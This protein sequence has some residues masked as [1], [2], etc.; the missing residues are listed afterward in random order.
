MR[1]ATALLASAAASDGAALFASEPKAALRLDASVVMTLML[2]IRAMKAWSARAL[3][4]LNGDLEVPAFV[5]VEALP[6]LGVADA[7]DLIN[8]LDYAGAL[9]LGVLDCIDT[10]VG[11]VDPARSWRDGSSLEHE[12]L[13]M[14][15]RVFT[16]DVLCAIAA[17]FTAREADSIIL[18]GDELSG[19]ESRFHAWEP[20]RDA[21]MFG[22]IG[23]THPALLRERLWEESPIEHGG[24]AESRGFSAPRRA[25]TLEG[26]LASGRPLAAAVLEWRRRAD[27]AFPPAANAGA[28]LY[29]SLP[30]SALRD[31][32]VL[33]RQV[34]DARN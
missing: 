15:W 32:A 30:F 4:H 10:V 33:C 24:D 31:R 34:F 7:G 1:A 2:H 3:Q 12:C 16:A 8:I 25:A 6:S 21:L 9:F 17:C 26:W 27:A 5:P 22:A 11:A 14:E 29:G 19:D 18:A 20:M 13:R 28:G 23:A